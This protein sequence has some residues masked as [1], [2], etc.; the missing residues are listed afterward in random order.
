MHIYFIRGGRSSRRPHWTI[1]YVYVHS[2]VCALSTSIW[3]VLTCFGGFII[4]CGCSELL[5]PHFVE[6]LL[7]F[8]VCAGSLLCRLISALSASVVSQSYFPQN[9]RCSRCLARSETFAPMA[10]AA[11]I[12]RRIGTSFETC[13][14]CARYSGALLG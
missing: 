14:F 2:F 7:E 1:R 8:R 13:R 10:C 9:I 11:P 5:P 6:I 12:S 3:S 4:S